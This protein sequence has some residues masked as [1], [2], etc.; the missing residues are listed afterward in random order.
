MPS[1]DTE[2]ISSVVLSSLI[3]QGDA[4]DI[5][6]Q[7]HSANLC[8]WRRLEKMGAYLVEVIIGDQVTISRGGDQQSTREEGKIVICRHQCGCFDG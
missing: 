5:Q 2:C 4:C 7:L 3:A 8:I 1:L 6:K